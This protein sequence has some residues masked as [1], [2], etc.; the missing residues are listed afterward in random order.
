MKIT[1]FTSNSIRHHSLINRISK[2]GHKCFAVIEKNKLSNGSNKSILNKRYFKE[3]AKSEKK[4]L[5]NKS[6]SKKKI[7]FLYTQWGK[8][9]YLK[10]NKHKDFLNS[11]LY[12]VFGSSYI[13]GWLVNYLIKKK[14]INIHM[15]ISPYYKGAAC[16]FW[17][18]YDNNPHFVGATIHYLSKGID[19]GK[20][21][22][23]VLPSIKCKSDFDFTMRSALSA[24]KALISKIKNKSIF[25]LKSYS[26][27]KKKLIRYSKIED[28]NSSIIEK[29]SKKKS[30]TS[31]QY[32]KKFYI[33]PY[34]ET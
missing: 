2:L 15:G 18:V 12:I 33:N 16:N 20:I 3:V 14:A 4:I 26:Q 28:F 32:N 22:F 10:K 8:I 30:F 9:N 21:L 1:I 31:P 13:K 19:N 6:L 11:D 24:Q 5:K 25:K 23:H 29:Y 7:I 17:A 27:D 34:F